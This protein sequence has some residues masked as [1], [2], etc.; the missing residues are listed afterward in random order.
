MIIVLKIQFPS[1]EHWYHVDYFSTFILLMP[2]IMTITM[3]MMGN[4]YDNDN[5]YD[6]L[7]FYIENNDDENC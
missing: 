4:N 6:S 7:D 3:I 2:M 1:A 5:D